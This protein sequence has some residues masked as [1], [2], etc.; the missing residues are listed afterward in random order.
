VVKPVLARE[1]ILEMRRVA[2]DVA[3]A[4][5]V[6]DYAIRVL[7]ATHPKN[8]EAPPL[9]KRFVRFGASPRGAQACLVAA[10][11]QALFDGRFQVGVDDVRKVARPSLRHR[12]ILNFEGEAEGVRPDQVLDEIL[13]TV[14]ETAK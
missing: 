6:Q 7:E 3:V 9:A 2:R 11:I 1:R 14:K 10:K 8:A 5:H 12:L 4:R 13:A